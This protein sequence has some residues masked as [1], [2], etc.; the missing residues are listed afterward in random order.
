MRR[1]AKT[2]LAAGALALL[3]AANVTP[4]TV[5]AQSSES[6]QAAPK[7]D[8]SNKELQNFVAAATAV[9]EVFDQWRPRISNAE[10]QE[11]RNQMRQKANDKAIEAIKE[12]GMPMKKYTEINQAVQGNPDLYDR[13]SKMMQNAQ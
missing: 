10:N 12:T 11:E 4:T 7:T 2:L 5:A 3:T 13:V 8:W 9:Q 1:Y 6:Q